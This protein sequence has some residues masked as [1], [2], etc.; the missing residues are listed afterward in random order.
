M[1][2]ISAIFGKPSARGDAIESADAA[3]TALARIT[4]ERAEAERVITDSA[5][6]RREL[7]LVD[8]SDKDIAKLDADADAARLTIERLDAI[9]PGIHARLREFLDAA[10][11][12][13]LAELRGIYLERISSLDAA[14]AAA[15]DE[16]DEYLEIV[17]QLDSAGFS[18]EARAFVVAPPTNG[19][20]LV[21]TRGTLEH[22]RRSR[23]A[24]ADMPSA[25]AR[26]QTP[27]P[28]AAPRVAAPPIER[29]DP[30][31]RPRPK[32]APSKVE[33]PPPAGF[34][35]IL[36]LRDGLE[37]DEKQHITGDEVIVS[38]T[39][40]DTLARKGAVEIVER[41]EIARAAE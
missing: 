14:M 26:R 8:G 37:L 5:E 15:L 27:R 36:V 6:R 23:E 19:A 18:A 38:T 30:E 22:F 1:G 39:Q 20:G 3:R 4:Q 16:F 41:G 21:L 28:A 33:G 10:R 17:R 13:L 31:Y 34:S 12:A 2:I 7:L 25:A 29:P 32:R 9:E 11:R 35:K 24:I 40:A